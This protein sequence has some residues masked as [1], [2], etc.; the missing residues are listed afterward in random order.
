MEIKG[1]YQPDDY[2]SAYW[3]HIKPRRSY[4]LVGCL[5]IALSLGMTWYLFFG[6]TKQH[7]Y[8]PGFVILGGFVYIFLCFFVYI[9][10]RLKREYR[11]QKH[12]QKEVTIAITENSLNTQTE[13]G[14]LNKPW[15]DYLK[16]KE[17]GRMFLLY[18]SDSVY[19]IVPKRFF[20]SAL[21]MD[22]FRKSLGEKVRP[23]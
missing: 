22:T 10:F 21:D 4:A 8:W 12:S 20:L 19:M 2:V 11:Q 6:A 15:A 17:G 14:H 23:C 18:Y 5:L 3:L 16:W 1:A 7:S 9:P 13:N